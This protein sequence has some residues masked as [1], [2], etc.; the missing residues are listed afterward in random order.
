MTS[1]GFSEWQGWSLSLSQPDFRRSGYYCFVAEETASE[2]LSH[3]HGVVQLEPGGNPGV[4]P[5]PGLQGLWVRAPL[6]GLIVL[7]VQ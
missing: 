3:E 7:S 1:S 6:L 4:R 2:K 5:G